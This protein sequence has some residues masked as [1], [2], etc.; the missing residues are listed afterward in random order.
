MYLTWEKRPLGAPDD[1][2]LSNK[3]EKLCKQA[4]LAGRIFGVIQFDIVLMKTYTISTPQAVCV[5][6]DQLKDVFW[7]SYTIKKDKYATL[8]NV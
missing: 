2:C 5:K 4:K 3:R 8:L 6:H 1:L 7:P